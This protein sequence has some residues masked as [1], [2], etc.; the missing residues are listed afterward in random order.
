MGLGMAKS[1]Q[2]FY[3]LLLTLSLKS[4]VKI[5]TLE[6]QSLM[7]SRDPFTFLPTPYPE[8]SGSSEQHVWFCSLPQGE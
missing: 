1:L 7:R 4:C 2:G 6:L 5:R 8:G 3:K